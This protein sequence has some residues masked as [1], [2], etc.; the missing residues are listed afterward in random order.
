MYYKQ[1]VGKK[2]VVRYEVLEKYKDPLTGKW[3]VATVSY[4]KDTR[5]A[6]LQAERELE[7]KIEKL[8][9]E[10][11]KRID[12]KKI[13]TFG[14]LK[15][16]WLNHWIPT[17]KH[18][19][20]RRKKDTLKRLEEIIGEDYLLESMSPLFMKGVLQDYVEQFDPSKGT[21]DHIK[22]TLS[23]V[24]N[25]GVLYGII[26][27]SPMAVV[28]IS[29]SSQKKYECRQRRNQKFL[30][31]HELKAFFAELGKRRNTNYYDLALFLLFAGLRIG[32][33][34]AITNGRY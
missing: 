24:F 25:H 15:E 29:V 31:V 30:E 11:V 10:R 16:D 26:K 2:G 17:V 13:V 4:F 23:Q 18:S 8:T 20:V 6:R 19:T 7:E 33:A 1:K 22:S 34:L 14:E 5:R 12:E 27:F 3:R 21:F 28:K 32:E 9:E